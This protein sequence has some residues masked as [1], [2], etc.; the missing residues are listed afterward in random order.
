MTM[1]LLSFC[2]TCTSLLLR[3]SQKTWARCYSINH[4]ADPDRR[5]SFLRP[6][7]LV[8]RQVRWRQTDL[9]QQRQGLRSSPAIRNEEQGLGRLTMGTSVNKLLIGLICF[10]GPS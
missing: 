6:K 9:S 1:Q 7:L 10:L 8:V 2:R 4:R 3:P 5:R